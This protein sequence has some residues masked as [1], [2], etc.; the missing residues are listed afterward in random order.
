MP[1][2]KGDPHERGGETGAP[3]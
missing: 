1:L 3:S 2:G